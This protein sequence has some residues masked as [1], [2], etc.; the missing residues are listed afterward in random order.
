MSRPPISVP[1]TVGEVGLNHNGNLALA[2]AMIALAAG[3]GVDYVKFQKRVPELVYKPEYL[4][5]QRHSMWGTT[6]RD[7]KEGLEFGAAEYDDI[8]LM[9][10]RLGI[11]WFASVWDTESLAFMLRY[12]PPFI[13]IPS[14]C[15]NHKKL[16]KAVRD[17]G[18]PVIAS[19]GMSTDEEVL[20]FCEDFRDQRYRLRYLLS[21]VALYPA[22][23]EEIELWR[24]LAISMPP[25]CYTGY[26]NHSPHVLPCIQAAIVGARMIEFHFTLDRSLPG[27]DHASS[28]GAADIRALQDGIRMVKKAW[29]TRTVR[30][31]PIFTPSKAEL[32]KGRHYLWRE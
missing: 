10:K 31:A 20:E 16:V 12:E 29:G 9:C 2:K 22:K 32:E 21:C 28:F 24:M 19:T 23:A 8:A 25:D 1:L 14:A 3:N 5:Q 15:L 30:P 7:Q 18:A 13:K 17:C 6:I 11:G 4:N 27:P 26:S